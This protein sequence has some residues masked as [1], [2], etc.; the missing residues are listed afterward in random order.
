MQHLC[1]QYQPAINHCAEKILMSRPR[2]SLLSESLALLSAQA[3]FVCVD[4]ET[5][6]LPGEELFAIEDVIDV[7][8]KMALALFGFCMSYWFVRLNP[9]HLPLPLNNH[10][11]YSVLSDAFP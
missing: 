11:G 2:K 7:K 9:S 6:L 3:C 5:H 8:V 1:P 10:A 4:V